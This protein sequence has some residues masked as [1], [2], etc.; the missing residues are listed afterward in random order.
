MHPSYAPPAAVFG[1]ASAI[2][3]WLAQR[4][5]NKVKLFQQEELEVG[6][7]KGAGVKK[8]H[9]VVVTPQPLKAPLSDTPCAWYRVQVQEYVRR[10]RYSTWVTIH[11][12][13]SHAPFQ[14]K[15]RKGPGAIDVELAGAEV[16]LAGEGGTE[17]HGTIVRF[18]EARGKTRMLGYGELRAGETTLQAGEKIFILG[19]VEERTGRYVLTK[20]KAPFVLSD[21]DSGQVAYRE[22][23]SMYLVRFWAGLSALI[24]L[25]WLW[26]L[27]R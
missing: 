4:K 2:G 18:L 12:E 9:G 11:D 6:D 25:Y 3:F 15:D 20:G 14:L 24:A 5:A 1:V 13:A 17:D 7:V 19:T 8:V 21:T 27:V 16:L 22:N 23:T 10:G 26:R